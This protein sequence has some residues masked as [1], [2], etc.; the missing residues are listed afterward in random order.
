MPNGQIVECYIVF[1]AMDMCKKEGN[2]EDE[3]YV[4]VTITGGD[5]SGGRLVEYAVGNAKDWVAYYPQRGQ[6]PA[7]HPDKQFSVEVA[8]S[9]TSE[10]PEP[11]VVKVLGKHL[12]VTT[13]H[14][15][16]Y[17][18]SNHMVFEN[19]RNCD[20]S[21]LTREER[22]E[23]KKAQEASTNKYNEA[24]VI[25]LEDTT[26]L[27]FEALFECFEVGNERRVD[28]DNAKI[29][30]TDLMHKV[31]HQSSMKDFNLS[32]K[33][34]RR[35]SGKTGN[36][37]SSSSAGIRRAVGL[38]TFRS[39]SSGAGGKGSSRAQGISQHNKMAGVREQQ[40]AEQ[41]A[42]SRN[43]SVGAEVDNT[44]NPM[45]ARD[46]TI[47]TMDTDFFRGDEG[48]GGGGGSSQNAHTLQ[49]QN[50]IKRFGA[51]EH[52]GSSKEI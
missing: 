15:P 46:P 25:T 13:D 27:E 12:R 3:A 19:W 45:Y 14:G 32:S 23:M 6:W 39:K 44:T 38:G 28:A 20:Q 18:L 42:G 9:G 35:G 4:D 40:E 17:K 7:D 49:T 37:E 22:A 21:K 50:S 52:Q 11:T 24:F 16:V 48:G 2:E 1:L 26:R 30:Y 34:L 29:V 47:T 36:T 33:H 31:L 43:G 5:F 51:F 8:G 10:K 41:Q